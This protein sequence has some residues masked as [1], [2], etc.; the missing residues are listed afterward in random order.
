MIIQKDNEAA[1]DKQIIIVDDEICTASQNDAEAAD[2]HRKASADGMQHMEIPVITIEEGPTDSGTRDEILHVNVPKKAGRW[3]WFLGGLVLSAVLCITAVCCWRHYRTYVNIGIPVSQTSQDNIARLAATTEKQAPSVVMTSDSILGVALNF[4]AI[5]GLKAEIAF[6]EPDTTDTSVFLY[7]R[8]ADHGKNG[9]CIGSLVANGRVMQQD[10]TRLGYC[11]MVADNIVIGIARDEDVM[12]YVEEQG[13]SFFRQFILVSNGV[14]PSQFHLH[15]KVERRGLGR[16][17]SQLYY[18]ET[19]HAETMW[20]FA[21]ALREYG[22]TD[23]IYITGGT[24]YSFYRTADGTRHD[25][26]DPG[27][28][29]HK[30]WKGIIPWL[31][32][33]KR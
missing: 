2:V 18:I 11:A 21:D 8:S 12:D 22:F 25:I 14:I 15:G 26:G 19:R 4:Y 1:Y 33:K 28:Y 27:N 30:K 10:A 31:V 23:A 13:G 20:D 6:Q 32:F 5:H 29:P 9:E 17:G 3:L 16:I 7:S 24:D